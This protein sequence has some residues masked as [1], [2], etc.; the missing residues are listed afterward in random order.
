MS[1]EVTGLNVEFLERIRGRENRSD[2]QVG[3]RHIDAVKKVVVRSGTI[4]VYDYAF[5]LTLSVCDTVV[6]IRNAGH[7]V[8]QLQSIATVERKVDDALL[9]DDLADGC[10][11][12][13]NGLSFRG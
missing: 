12:Q 3:V 5:M 9:V 7:D 11:D 13:I 2:R 8:L 10:I 1:G 4:S 6:V